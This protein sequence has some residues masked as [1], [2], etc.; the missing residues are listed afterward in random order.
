MIEYLINGEVGV[1]ENET[2]E[3]VIDLLHSDE[4]KVND[5]D[6]VVKNY[7]DGLVH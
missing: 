4:V 7:Y 5:V 3:F 1:D 2:C 6:A